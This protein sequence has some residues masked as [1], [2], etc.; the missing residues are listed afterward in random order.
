MVSARDCREITLAV[1]SCLFWWAG[2]SERR[3]VAEACGV[4][5]VVF[6]VLCGVVCCV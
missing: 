4:V 3:N 6:C 1:K 5:C 2:G